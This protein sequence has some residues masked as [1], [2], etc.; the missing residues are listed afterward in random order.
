MVKELWE[1][2]CPSSFFDETN[3]M[4]IREIQLDCLIYSL[5]RH[6]T[7]ENIQSIRSLKPMRA[8][9]PT[10]FVRMLIIFECMLENAQN[11]RICEQ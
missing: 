8:S 10:M 9:D 5:V 4:M 2:E 11:R 1:P 7:L 3:T 6:A